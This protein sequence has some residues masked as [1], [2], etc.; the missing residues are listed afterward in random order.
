MGAGGCSWGCSGGS[1]VGT[2][3][4]ASE[5]TLNTGSE[6]KASFFPF[7]PLLLCLLPQDL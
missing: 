6:V 5:V 3:E 4:P 7:F 1:S 2:D